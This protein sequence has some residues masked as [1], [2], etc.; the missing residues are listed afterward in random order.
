MLSFR[1]CSCIQVTLF[2][3]KPDLEFKQGL[4]DYDFGKSVINIK[5][6]TNKISEIGSS[7]PVNA[8][9]SSPSLAECVVLSLCNPGDTLLDLCCGVGSIEEAACRLG[10]HTVAMDI[11]PVMARTAIQRIQGLPNRCAVAFNK[12]YKLPKADLLPLSLCP[13]ALASFPENIKG[14]IVLPFI[15]SGETFSACSGGSFRDLFVSCLLICVVSRAFFDQKFFLKHTLG[16]KKNFCHVFVVFLLCFCNDVCSSSRPH[17][18]RWPPAA[19]TTHKLCRLGK[20]H[21]TQQ[22]Q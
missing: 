17:S 9:E 10:V 3:N 4:S 2:V 7:K 1:R 13:T 19:T 8:C 22:R 16:F 6:T 15:P 12:A 5:K 11:N 20:T 14:C 21:S 18:A